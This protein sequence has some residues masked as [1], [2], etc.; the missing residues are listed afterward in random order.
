MKTKF[1]ACAFLL[2]TTL[3]S[4]FTQ[5]VATKLQD[6]DCGRSGIDVNQLLYA[7]SVSGI[8]F[9]Q[10]TVTNFLGFNQS[11]IS[12]NRFFS[13]SQLPGPIAYSAEYYVKIR[14]I[15]GNDTSS[16]G[17]LCNI[18]TKDNQIP[19]DIDESKMPAGYFQ[20]KSSVKDAP[21]YARFTTASGK[22]ELVF[23]DLI[24]DDGDGF[25]SEGLSGYYIPCLIEA[26]EYI[27]QVFDINITD[28]IQ[29]EINSVHTGLT[30][31]LATATPLGFGGLSNTFYS[32]YMYEHL[33]SGT[34]P[35]EAEYDGRIAFNFDFSYS[36]ECNDY[37]DY[38]NIN[39]YSVMLHEVTHLLGFF[40]RI[41]LTP[42]G[43]GSVFG[44]NVF[45]NFDQKYIYYNSDM[46]GGNGILTQ[47]VHTDLSGQ[48]VVDASFIYND[49]M[50]RH[51]L[52]LNGDH[53]INDN[54]NMP[55][56]FSKAYYGPGSNFSHLD[57]NYYL[58]EADDIY[59]TYFFRSHN[60]PKF[61]PEFVMH[62]SYRPF[63]PITAYSNQEIRI[64]Q[65][66]G[67]IINESYMTD[68]VI[69]NT[70]PNF[71]GFSMTDNFIYD[72]LFQ[73]ITP[74][75]QH[76]SNFYYSMDNDGSL[77][78][79]DIN[80]MPDIF[81]AEGQHITVYGGYNGL[82]NIRG[83]GNGGNNHNQL[84]INAA[85]DIITFT[86][87]E[88]FIGRAQFAFNLYDGIEPGAYVVITVDVEDG[89]AFENSPA[90]ELV[91]N[92]TFEEGSEVKL[93]SDQTT[94][95][96]H[97]YV[98]NSN[99]NGCADGKQ[100]NDSWRDDVIIRDSYFNCDNLRY[101]GLDWTSF[102]SE[103]TVSPESNEFTGLD[104]YIHKGAT[105]DSIDS[106]HPETFSITL[107]EPMIQGQCYV[108]K[109]DIYSLV[110]TSVGNNDLYI[111]FYD[112]LNVNHLIEPPLVNYFYDGSSIVSGEWSSQQF[113]IP[114]FDD[115]ASGTLNDLKYLCIDFT[116]GFLD[117]VSLRKCG[118]PLELSTDY[119]N[120]CNGNDGSVT[121]LVSGGLGDYSYV[122]STG[123]TETTSNQ[124]SSLSD[125][126]AGTYSVT[127]TDANGMTQTTSITLNP[128]PAGSP[129]IGFSG[130]DPVC[131]GSDNGTITTTITG[132]TLPYSYLWDNFVTIPNQSGLHGG[133]Y[134]LTVT[135]S[136]GCS[137]VD[138][139]EL[140][141]PLPLY[142]STNLL[143]GTCVGSCNGSSEIIIN[144]STGTPPYS[145]EWSDGETTAT[146]INLCAGINSVLV[147]DANG[148]S[149]I[150]VVDI[151]VYELITLVN[152]IS[153]PECCN[154]EVNI[155]IL[156]G[157]SNY[158]W[159]YFG[160]TVVS[161]S[162]NVTPDNL[163]AGNYI[164]T[165]TDGIG[166]STTFAFDLESI[167]M[168][169]VIYDNIVPSYCGTCMGQ[170][171]L[172]GVIVNG[173]VHSP[174][175][176]NLHWS[177]GET[178]AFIDEL[179][180]GLYYLTVTSVPGCDFLSYIEIPEQPLEIDL[181]VNA[182]PCEG[183]SNGSVE[184]IVTPDPA[185]YGCTYSY[186]WNDPSAQTT[187]T[188]TGLG[189]GFY[190]V[191]VT[192]SCLG[193]SGQPC[194]ASE[195]V[196]IAAIPF[197]I[198][199]TETDVSCNG[200]SDGTAHLEIAGG[201]PPFTITWVNNLD[202]YTVIG[203][204]YDI[205][206]LPYGTYTVSVLDANGCAQTSEVS[207]LQPAPLE[208]NIG[209]IVS[210]VCLNS[211]DGIMYYNVGGGTHPY[212]YS[213]FDENMNPVYPVNFAGEYVSGLCAGDYTVILT[214]SHDCTVSESFTINDP[215]FPLTTT[216]SVSG[217]T[218]YG[219]CNGSITLN[220]SGGTPPYTYL[221]SN[222]QTTMTATNLCSG[223]Y[224]YTITDAN[225]C[226][227]APMFTIYV[228]Q[229][230]MIQIID[231][232]VVN[233]S[234]DDGNDGLINISVTGGT[235][236]YSY[237]WISFDGSG[238]APGVQDQ[239]GLTAGT[240]YL[241]VTDQNNCKK[242]KNY[243]LTEIGNPVVTT[244]SSLIPGKPIKCRITATVTG[245]TPPYQ[246]FW[247]GSLLPG[248][249][250]K[251]V[252]PG[253]SWS[254]NVIDSKSCITHV[255]GSSACQ[256]PPERGKEDLVNSQNVNVYPNPT[257]GEL[258]IELSFEESEKV[259]LSLYN[260]IGERI[261]D[262]YEGSVY[263]DIFTVNF[264]DIA[265]G[266]YM[267][268]IRTDNNVFIE[269]VIYK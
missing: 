155:V 218:C 158:T 57:R 63:E 50:L 108:L 157:V 8:N 117:N 118:S 130:T 124:Y 77:L 83:C 48:P 97:Y 64:L 35:S 227:Y 214:D 29:I 78:Q 245:G 84:T 114:S 186:Q 76:N 33:M 265:K 154:G 27:E 147:T 51:S 199:T 139:I 207:I 171:E 264:K 12:Q 185:L 236:S 268:K 25:D 7:D 232:L 122:W 135:D 89:S 256:V 41:N 11:L 200:L 182:P 191:Q 188:A 267:V 253:S 94:P 17:N 90:D 10:F 222:G 217:A 202:P 85:N 252:T 46:P 151:P 113:I 13:L 30:S 169:D 16:Y 119:T 211:C 49:V 70:P 14:T 209:N 150:E 116:G 180:A 109:F 123:F 215:A 242:T 4:L 223:F 167:G 68:A 96:R 263:E 24:E 106:D 250:Y 20:S 34:D 164:V 59:G 184:A 179:C 251:D 42:T 140:V 28:T 112:E 156:N 15:L 107:T 189:A 127:V 221:W 54:T 210:T 92:G 233:I 2:F 98:L 220:P 161:V 71:K 172:T 134:S 120:I 187:A 144:E 79:F 136:F 190:T 3:G 239:D 81:D 115:G 67:Y 88:N 198:A 39:M 93:L 31:G 142:T 26:M 47:L 249:T 197:S 141:D 45:T 255:S 75:G 159:E 229:P 126:S 240:Y 36:T 195:T 99:I 196:Y 234:C 44:T 131:F 69:E 137:D 87:R 110:N 193:Q 23:T 72:E 104:R 178:T 100:A 230:T 40:S 228:S 128:N 121:V 32:G 149:D 224:G 170:A 238:I 43:I 219:S 148:C 82:V 95:F 205:T 86:P 248:G 237:Q 125:L 153:E 175:G 261:M 18:Y 74:P 58:Y 143:E 269:K 225:G 65:E 21:A 201:T 173:V 60:A 192:S 162:N 102:G 174:S 22:F 204:G 231:D 66:L 254:L 152:I 257:S 181:I 206:N 73:N 105:G 165:V 129:V 146:A 91:I 55:I 203:T 243:T 244:T 111:G 101:F 216:F 53:F 6:S 133:Q 235:G 166:C 62:P 208:F 258:N 194:F 1:I 183:V 5:P 247:N 246:Y 260:M 52:W 9:Y 241:T 145:I 61:V 163:C 266:I 177:N 132:G 213:W 103:N 212:D 259:E 226:I 168:D 176:Y 80:N 37:T 262:I 160:N 138:S 56:A 19:Y 38:C